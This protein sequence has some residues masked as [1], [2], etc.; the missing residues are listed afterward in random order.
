M[1][2]AISQIHFGGEFKRDGEGSSKGEGIQPLDYNL[3]EQKGNKTLRGELEQP[4]IDDDIGADRDRFAVFQR[5]FE[6]PLG[7]SFNGLFIET[8]AE[9]ARHFNVGGIAVGVDDDAQAHFALPLGLPG[10]F[11]VLGF[12]PENGHGRRNAAADA[13][14]AAAKTAAFPGPKPL[15][16]PDPTPPPLPLPMPPPKPVP[17]EGIPETLCGRP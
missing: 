1:A 2:A 3:P 6:P 5:G 16:L 9:R 10:F 13:V 14:H 12:R 8:Q 11:G 15:P 7:H 17:F 4:E